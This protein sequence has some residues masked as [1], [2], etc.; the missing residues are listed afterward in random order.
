MQ[1]DLEKTGQLMFVVSGLSGVG[2]DAV[3]KTVA[4]RGNVDFCFVITTTS[5]PP[6]PD[7]VDEVD[8][9]F[10]SEERFQEMV[11]NDELVEHAVVYGQNKG[12]SKRAIKI[13]QESGR[14]IMIRVDVQGAASVRAFYPKAVLI[15]MIPENFEVWVERLRARG[16][17]SEDELKIR[18]E[19]AKNELE[20]AK[21]IFDYV[22]INEDEH[23]KDAADVLESIIL[24]EHHRITNSGM[25]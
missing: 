3:I 17:E 24:A 20:A 25:I 19:K 4:D 6:R 8:Y 16:S 1:F 12:I 22:I 10:V 11:D 13:A 21:Q 5:R 7:E 15:F 9:F 2:K 14:D 23:L 18:I